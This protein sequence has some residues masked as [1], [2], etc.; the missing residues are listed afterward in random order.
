VC[1]ISDDYAIAMITALV[2]AGFRVP[3][4]VAVIGVDDVPAAAYVTPSLTTVAA[5]FAALADAVAS[6]VTGLL[7]GPSDRTQL[8]LPDHHLVVRES[9]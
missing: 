4:D 2:A 8:P 7:A 6:S 3:D 9:A 1:A 5:D